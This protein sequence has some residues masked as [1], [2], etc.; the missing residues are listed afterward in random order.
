MC[1]DR[2]KDKCSKAESPV[3]DLR[4]CCYSINR[5]ASPGIAWPIWSGIGNGVD[6]PGE[7]GLPPHA[8]HRASSQ[9]GK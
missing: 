4:A 7:K 1:M 9:H 5:K 8:V 6:S 2:Y 3:T